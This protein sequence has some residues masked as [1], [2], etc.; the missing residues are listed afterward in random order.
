MT[1]FAPSTSQPYIVCCIC[2][3]P[4]SLETSKSDECGK[5]V[6]EDCYVRKTI[7]R[8]RIASP[9]DARENWLN[10]M[11]MRFQSDSVWAWVSNSDRG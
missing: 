2:A 6:H 9:V 7:S 11:L 4:V 10:S 8:F 5:A 1:G 3:E